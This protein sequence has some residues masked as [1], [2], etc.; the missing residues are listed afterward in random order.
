[1]GKLRHHIRLSEH[2]SFYFSASPC[3]CITDYLPQ[4]S[5]Q[6]RPRQLV[7]FDDIVAISAKH[8]L[9]TDKLKQR[10][11]ELLDLYDDLRRKKLE[12]HVE[13]RLEALRTR[14]GEHYGHD[15]I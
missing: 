13:K 15:L 6:F 4:I 9:H 12:I 14:S 5:E 2:D 11:R 10:L 7:Q 1:M 3:C 8:R